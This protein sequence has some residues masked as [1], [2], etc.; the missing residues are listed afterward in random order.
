GAMPGVYRALWS[1]QEL[2][3]ALALPATWQDYVAQLG[4]RTRRKLAYYQRLLHRRCEKV[5]L[6]LA[7]R[8]ELTAL[9]TA[10]FDLHGKRWRSRDMPGH[11]A[12]SRLQ[13]FHRRVAERFHARGWLRP[14]IAYLGGRAV[15]VEYAFCFH[16]RYYL[17]LAGLDP[18][19]YRYSL[20]TVLMAEAIRHAI[21]EGCVEVDFLRGN[22]SYKLAW[23]PTQ[24]RLNRRLVLVHPASIRSH[25]ALWVDGLRPHLTT[26]RIMQRRL[27]RA[28][29]RGQDYLVRPGISFP[30]YKQLPW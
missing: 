23:K 21:A 22:E 12:S 7:E 1:D 14:H 2:C 28:W 3:L 6:R 25:A 15:A 20:G 27:L 8:E 9:M 16:K 24:E 19:W 4:K 30:D 29:S 5:D 10:L 18:E 11:L 17:Y 13:A 26:V